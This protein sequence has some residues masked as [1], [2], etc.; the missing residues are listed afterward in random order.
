[1]TRF[2]ATT[3]DL[4]R[5]PVPAVIKDL[6]K[7]TIE[8]ERIAELVARYNAASIEYDVDQLQYDPGIILQQQDAYRELLDKQGI[9]DAA[10]A[11]MVPYAMNS[12]LDTLGLRFGV[13]RLDGE[14]D[15]RFRHRI[16]LA[17]GAYSSA[18]SIDAYRYHAMSVAT[19]IKDVGVYSPAPG[20]VTVAVLSTQD[21]GAPSDGTV[22]LVRQV[23]LDDEI[24]PLTDVV[25]VK[26]AVIVPYTIDFKLLIPDGPDPA[27]VRAASLAALEKLVVERQIVGG[28]VH[29][30]ALTAAA[31]VSN[32]LDVQPIEP[33][34]DIVVELDQAAY[35]AGITITSEVAT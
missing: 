7:D 30:S 16:Q 33:M 1:M 35:C 4:S 12:N 14:N 25:T 23:L 2:S 19:S 22:Y 34:A 31:H 11:V 32:V 21:D 29:L 20:Q 13:E 18:G 27:I 3:L 6:D 17:P 8:A 10:K 26:A 15:A 9:N 5:L 28:T 24:K